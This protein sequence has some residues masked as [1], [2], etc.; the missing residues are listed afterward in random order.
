MEGRDGA[1]RRSR[2]F[3]RR[4]STRRFVWSALALAVSGTF[5]ITASP[6]GGPAADSAGGNKAAV[7]TANDKSGPVAAASAGRWVVYA[8]D[9]LR[10][11]AKGIHSRNRARQAQYIAAVRS[12]NPDVAGLA[13]DAPMPTGLQL[14]L[15]DLKALSG[16]APNA[17]A[18]P[19]AAPRR[20]VSQ[21]SESAPVL[22][23]PQ[24]APMAREPNEAVTP[25][26]AASPA[27]SALPGLWTVRA[28][29]TM[30]TL[31]TAIY[32]TSR[33]RQDIYIA[34][35]RAMNPGL[36][37]VADDAVLEASSQLGMPDLKKLSS[38]PVAGTSAPDKAHAHAAK[39]AAA[40]KVV[41]PPAELSRAPVQKST[42]GSAS[43]ALPPPTP[44]APAA[45]HTPMP[46]DSGFRLKLS[47]AEIDLSRSRNMSESDRRALR[48]NRLLLDADD[49]QA[50]LLSLRNTI[51]QLEARISELQLKAASNIAA[52][53]GKPV[54][55]PPVLPAAEPRPAVVLPEPASPPPVIAP[56]TAPAPAPSAPAGKAPAAK[57]ANAKPAPDTSTKPTPA[58]D[59]WLAMLT[60]MPA[61]IAIAAIAIALLGL[62]GWSRRRAGPAKYRIDNIPAAPA[63]A[64]ETTPRPDDEDAAV[65]SPAPGVLQ[66]RLV[67]A[68]AMR[69]IELTP[70]ANA[71]AGPGAAT[72]ADNLDAQS[73]DV[74]LKLD[75]PLNMEDSQARFDLD[76]S[77]TTTVD[78]PVGLD[79]K[80]G[81]DRVRRLQYMYERYPE[82]MTHTVSIDD[83]DSVINAA[84]LYYEED[85]REKACELLTFGVEERPQETRFWLAQFEIFRLENMVAEFAEL[86][87]KFHVLFGNSPA[88]P[89]VRHIGHELDPTNTL[90]AAAGRDAL[91]GEMHF[92]PV[93]ENWLNAPMDFT[94]DALT[95]DLRLAL[96]DDHGVDRPDFESITARLAAG[97]TPA[98]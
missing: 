49:Q 42:G 19:V 56:E 54:A 9:T 85:H 68:S 71:A 16:L 41:P 76:V 43:A 69:E 53:L 14:V 31:A 52:P 13:E 84:R 45:R 33:A 38:I 61:L 81:E 25:Q 24:P 20:P 47:G 12:L 94:S 44:S 6:Q 29:D 90:F 64:A 92:D 40:R 96:F 37:G 87:S 62:L 35:L 26:S 73:F 17:I 51:R 70:H 60:S 18:Y 8:G 78:F 93:A 72:A 1:A 57:A 50:A 15:P 58:D 11:L 80:P 4:G 34:E 88:W 21:T 97:A 46:P 77:P 10:S 75:N 3:G 32:P 48:E 74:T 27:P 95:S 89:K 79:D 2:Q 30:R 83:A 7:T 67:D 65:L 91:A 86:A 98:R 63:A 39:P 22:A 5:V 59:D 28:G 82:L 36:G 66:Q 55:A 23:P